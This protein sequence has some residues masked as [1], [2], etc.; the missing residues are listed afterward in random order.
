MYI[1]R[2]EWNGKTYHQ[3]IAGGLVERHFLKKAGYA[4]DQPRVL[5]LP[6]SIFTD[7]GVRLGESVIST[8]RL[9][10]VDYVSLVLAA[11]ARYYSERAGEPVNTARDCKRVAKAQEHLEWIET[12]Q[13]LHAAHGRALYSRKYGFK[14]RRPSYARLYN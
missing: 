10:P 9:S 7:D 8:K 6:G 12:C 11:A 2:K 5:T 3:L 14:R 13:H 1:R 4:L